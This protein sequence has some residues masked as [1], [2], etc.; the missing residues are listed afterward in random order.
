[1][2][3]PGASTIHVMSKSHSR[4]VCTRSCVLVV[5][6]C[7]SDF[8]NPMSELSYVRPLTL[9]ALALDNIPLTLVALTLDNISCKKCNPPENPG[10][11][12]A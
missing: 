2:R 7:T 11:G 4:N 10:Y 5:C 8:P 3:A 1:M 9:V 6:M 12:S